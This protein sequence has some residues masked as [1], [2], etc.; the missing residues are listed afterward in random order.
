[1]HGFR[2]A[3]KKLRRS[4]H[5]GRE[6]IG[7]REA[8]AACVSESQGWERSRAGRSAAEG[9]GGGARLVAGGGCH[10][11]RT[12]SLPEAMDADFSRPRVG[13][14]RLGLGGGRDVG[15]LPSPGSLRPDRAT[16]ARPTGSLGPIA[17]RCRSKSRGA[18]VPLIGMQPMRHVRT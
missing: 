11:R 3:D 8:G 5:C 16:R 6:G 17:W 9:G 1:M 10:H 7:L 13:P 12:F 14:Y 15:L 2:D 4:R 18:V